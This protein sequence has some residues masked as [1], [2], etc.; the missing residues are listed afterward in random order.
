MTSRHKWLVN[1]SCTQNQKNYRKSCF[2][3]I[4][5]TTHLKTLQEN[6]MYSTD[7]IRSTS[8]SISNTATNFMRVYYFIDK[9][10]TIQLK[11][12]HG[13]VTSLSAAWPSLMQLFAQTVDKIAEYWTKGQSLSLSKVKSVQIFVQQRSEHSLLYSAT[14]HLFFPLMRILMN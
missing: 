5:T 8:V 12:V 4:C 14:Y 2:I 3:I 13:D 11:S 9:D 7:A 10:V 6:W 1:Q